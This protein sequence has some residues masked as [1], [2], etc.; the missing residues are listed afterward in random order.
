MHT[1]DPSF[2]SLVRPQEAAAVS[3]KMLGQSLI[4]KQ[5]GAEGR[6]CN[7]V[8]V[9]E[10]LD[11]AREFYFAVLYDRKHQGPVIVASSQG[12]MDIEA[13]AHDNPSA[14]ITEPVDI[15]AGLS[16]EQAKRVAERIGFSGKQ[17]EDA[18][19]IFVGIFKLFKEKDATMVEINPLGET[20]NGTVL[21]MDAKINFDDNAEFRQSDVFELRDTSQEDSREVA[22]SKYN[23]NYIGLDG[24]IACLGTLFL[25][26]QSCRGAL[27]MRHIAFIAH[28]GRCQMCSFV[29]EKSGFRRLPL[30]E[31]VRFPL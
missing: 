13:V 14:I 27:S 16:L 5:T 1:C 7:A 6:P 3:A 15:H 28:H 10:R 19:R 25:S 26:F 29:V 30:L 9:V 21:C 18:A 12:G 20:K 22:A 2:V 31:T 8:Y 23:L 4:T 24:S 11:L 17:A